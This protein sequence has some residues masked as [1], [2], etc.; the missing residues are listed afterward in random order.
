MFARA[1][2]L[3]GKDQYEKK[4]AVFVCCVEVIFILAL[5]LH[6]S[7]KISCPIVELLLIRFLEALRA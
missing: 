5:F 3:N 4:L 2:R 6:A 1:H 7:P